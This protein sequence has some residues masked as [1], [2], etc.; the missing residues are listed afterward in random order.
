MLT[1]TVRVRDDFDNE[2]NKFIV[3]DVVLELE[4]SLVSLSKWEQKYEKPYLGDDKPTEEEA[5]YYIECMIMNEYPPGIVAKLGADHIMQVD[6]Y[7]NRKMTATWF[8]EITPETK[9]S[10]EKITA[11]LV[12]YWMTTLNIP[13]EA[14]NWH[15]SRLFTL[16]KIFGAKAEKPK[17][18]TGS[19]LRAHRSELNRKRR[20]EE[21]HDG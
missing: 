12:Y 15:L 19:E 9:K 2:E 10:N 16:I 6:T 18:M 1:L 7:I 14:Q 3:E 4:H 20:E 5:L 17:P 8:N 11:E 13:W 21:G